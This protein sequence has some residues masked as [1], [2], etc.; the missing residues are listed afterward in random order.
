MI[1]QLRRLESG[2]FGIHL[3]PTIAAIVHGYHILEV[4]DLAFRWA[5]L[6]PVRLVS[7]RCQNR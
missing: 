4:N 6:T 7:R 5:G 1:T 3:S 2:Q